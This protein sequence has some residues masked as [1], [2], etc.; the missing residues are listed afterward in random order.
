RSLERPETIARFAVSTRTQNLPADFYTNYLK[1]IDKVTAADVS[2]AVKATILPN[3]SRIFIAGKAADISEGLEKLGYP[4]KYYD[5]QANPVAKPV[6]KAVDASIT[7]AAVADKYI[8]AIGGLANVQKVN[9]I[10]TNATAK[11]QG[12]DLALKLIQGKGAKTFMDVQMMGNTVQK[13]VFDGKSGYMEAQGQKMPLPAETAAEMAMDTELFPELTFAK[14]SD[15]SVAGIEKNNGEDA[16]VVKGKNATYYYSTKTGLKT[17]EVKTQSGQTIP[18]TWGDYKEVAGVK[19]PYAF[20][21]NIG[22]MD[23][24]FKV[25]SYQ[26]NQATAADFK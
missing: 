6:A 3:R 11:V 4:V 5:N 2:N 10:T 9:F 26:I 12:M 24:E 22:G 21:Q 16:Y 23:V 1:S 13:I 14:S 18:I 20:T 15:F 17:G 7:P 25:N 8:A 19:M